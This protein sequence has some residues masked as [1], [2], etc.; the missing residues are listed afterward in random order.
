[1][2]DIFYLTVDRY[3]Q[4]NPLLPP[5]RDNPGG[6][7]S[8]KTLA[9]LKAWRR[10]YRVGVSERID[11][12]PDAEILVV[13]P[14]WFKLRGGL[15]DDLQSPDLEEAIA[16]YESHGAPIK[17]LDLSEFSFL[18]FPKQYR[19]RIIEAST[20]VTS[21][22]PYQKQ[23][24]AQFGIE[25]EHLCDP[26]DDTVLPSVQRPRTMSVV[27]FGRISTVKN[28]NKT[29]ELFR[30]LNQEPIETVYIGDAALW[31][32]TVGVDKAL[33]WEMQRV[34]DV[35]YPNITMASLMETLSGIALAVFD[36]FH[37]SCSGSNITALMSGLR[38][39]Y[40]LHGCWRGRPGV[41]ELNTVDDFVDALKTETDNFTTIPDPH[42]DRDW[43]MQRYGINAFLNDWSNLLKALNYAE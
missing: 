18:K 6:G 33:E 35:Y 12:Y 30:A 38:C 20:V 36:S 8:D 22:C 7:I 39:F 9:V 17:I 13:E 15:H 3:H 24:Y 11:H 31:G 25:T 16:A 28:S 40:G 19:D 32:D 26:V 41:G 37:D 4:Y 5:G 27:A 1:M 43:V 34:A 23:F 2:T 10:F 42:A 14:L 29:I 21:N